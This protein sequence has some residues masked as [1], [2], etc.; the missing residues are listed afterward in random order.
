MA[1]YVDT[2]VVLAWLFEEGRRPD[3]GFWL[4]PLYASR[5]TEYESWTRLHA[6]GLGVIHRERLIELLSRFSWLELSPDVLHRVTGPFPISLRTLD[7]FH[8][9]SADWLRREGFT[10]EFATYDARLRQAALVMGFPVV[11][12]AP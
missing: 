9:A 7:A 6:R 1:P 12:M 11:E 2:S 10:V 4:E 5:L 8:I 3:D